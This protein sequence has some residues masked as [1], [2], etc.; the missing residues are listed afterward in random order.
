MLLVGA[1]VAR[2]GGLI[3]LGFAS[4][5]ALLVTSIVGATTT[6]NSFDTKDLRDAPTSAAA[7]DSGYHVP[8]GT[9]SLDLREVRDLA[10]LD[11]RTVD[12]GTNAGEI[13]VIVPSGVNVHVVADVRYAGQINVGDEMRDGLGQSLETTLTSSAAP[14]TPTLHLTIEVRFGQITVA[15]N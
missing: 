12:L 11:G 6:G 7:V 8:S 15:R 10:A 5:I 2:P 3:A 14:G 9:I 13:D 1:F 4:S